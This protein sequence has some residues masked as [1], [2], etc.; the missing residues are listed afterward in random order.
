MERFACALAL[1]SLSALS[2]C[3]DEQFVDED[4][5]E[6]FEGCT[7][8]GCEDGLNILF[9]VS[10]PGAYLFN[11]VAD[12]ATISCSATLPLPDCSL[13]GSTCADPRVQLGASGC[14]LSPQEHSLEGLAFFGMQPQSVS[15]IATR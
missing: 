4:D 8:V 9:S 2:A 14:A 1:L 6:S 5:G 10:E 11:I 12:G 13:A 7:A 3:S 15:V